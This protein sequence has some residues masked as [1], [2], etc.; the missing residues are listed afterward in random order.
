MYRFNQGGQ[1]WAHNTWIPVNLP[2][3]TLPCACCQF[4]IV[5]EPDSIFYRWEH[6]KKKNLF[7]HEWC[8]LLQKVSVSNLLCGESE[9]VMWRFQ[10]E[11]VHVLVKHA[12]MFP[13]M[14]TYQN[15][16]TLLIHHKL[17]DH[18][19]QLKKLLLTEKQYSVHYVRIAWA[20]GQLATMDGL[21]YVYASIA[22]YIHPQLKFNLL[23]VLDER[24][25]L[26]KRWACR[27][28]A[29]MREVEVILRKREPSKTKGDEAVK[30]WLCSSAH[31]RS[32]SST[33]RKAYAH[34]V[35]QLF[36]V[37]T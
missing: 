31:C 13:T 3:G 21:M 6:P 22:D 18:S 10:Q 14:R 19:T 23:H 30:A 15:F 24:E 34:I 16:L 1:K 36:H 12:M 2:C 25:T 29:T 37:T 7:C 32:A 11:V 5:E 20:C 33:E 17:G 9:D 35:R 8:R 26:Q 28:I 27:L 4:S